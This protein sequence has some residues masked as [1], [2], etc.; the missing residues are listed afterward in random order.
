MLAGMGKRIPVLC[1]SKPYSD[2][3]V[4]FRT[5]LRVEYWTHWKIHGTLIVFCAN[6][7]LKMLRNIVDA[8]T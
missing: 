2:P 1:C 8:T 7:K 6:A 4:V 3:K 5:A